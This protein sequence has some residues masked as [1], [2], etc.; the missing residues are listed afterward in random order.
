MKLLN[1]V[2]L[3][4]AFSHFA[5]A[6][7]EQKVFMPL[8]YSPICIIEAVSSKLNIQ[9]KSE[10][11]LPDLHPHS[12][13]TFEEFKVGARFNYPADYDITYFANVYS[14]ENNAI[15]INDSVPLVG[16]NGR[17]S[18]DVLAHELTHYFQAQY[19]KYSLEE[20]S[21]DE[22]EEGAVRLQFWFRENYMTSKPASSPCPRTKGQGKEFSQIWKW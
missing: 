16:K 10:I 4:A 11:P 6:E 18:D 22:A 1:L 13:T 3:V 7:E 5:H 2:F 9:L 19:Q 15:Y 21:S 14:T 8:T 17:T 12:T 20:R